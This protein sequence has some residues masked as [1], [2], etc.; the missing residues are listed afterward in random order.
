MQRGFKSRF[1]VHESMFAILALNYDQLFFD[2]LSPFFKALNRS[3][4]SIHI[5]RDRYNF[6]LKH[7]LVG[8]FLSY[9]VEEYFR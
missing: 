5:N 1:E 4:V 3:G 9:K 8:Y 7:E 6:L 2:D